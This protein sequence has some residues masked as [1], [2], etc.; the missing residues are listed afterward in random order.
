MPHYVAIVEDV[1]PAKAVGI[2][3]P[4]LPGCFSAGDDID[5][6]LRNAGEALELYAVSLAKQGRALPVPRTVS[7]LKNDPAV[8]ADLR[9]HALAL[10]A[11][12]RLAADA[13][14]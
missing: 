9:D 7:A 2:W 6:A 10:I 8:A 3:F 4:D 11:L 1:G 5:E 13:A 14:E 12:R